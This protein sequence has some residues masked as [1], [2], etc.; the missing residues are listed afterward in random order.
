MVV[1]FALVTTYI[2]MRHIPNCIG[3]LGT[4]TGIFRCRRKEVTHAITRLV[5]LA[6]ILANSAQR[7]PPSNSVASVGTL[8]ADIHHCAIQYFL[9]LI[10]SHLH[11][12]IRAEDTK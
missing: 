1:G 5:I 3:D 2:V 7:V 12:A 6:C 4:W 8:D 10:G 11:P 9:P